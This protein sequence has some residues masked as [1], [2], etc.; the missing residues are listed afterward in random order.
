[1]RRVLLGGVAPRLP[2]R[3]SGVSIARRAFALPAAEPAFSLDAVVSREDPF[4]LLDGAVVNGN[5]KH[6]ELTT[7]GMLEYERHGAKPSPSPPQHFS[8][9]SSSQGAKGF[10]NVNARYRA[11]EL[12]LP[13]PLPKQRPPVGAGQ[14]HWLEE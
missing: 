3:N 9:I 1:M 11:E 4:L 6:G 5:C 2:L 13:P 7:P 8:E 12:D 10:P 14:E